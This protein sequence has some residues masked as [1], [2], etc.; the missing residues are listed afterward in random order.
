MREGE[1][2][3]I[4]VTLG[5][6]ETAQGEGSSPATPDEPSE[7]D[8]LGMSL[9]PLTPEMAQELGVSRDTKGVAITGVDPEGAAADKGLAPGDVI[10]DVNQQ[11]V[12][13]IKELQDRVAEAR[14]AGRK[15][16]LMLIRRGG[17]PLFVALSLDDMEKPAE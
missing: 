9:T 14:D 13:T 5:R 8:M 3:Q 17:E 15:S 6:R 7:T 12:T 2:Q 4:D 11:K 16:V 10:T 1:T